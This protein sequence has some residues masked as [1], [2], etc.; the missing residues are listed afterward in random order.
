MANIELKVS[1]KVLA[2]E[3]TADSYV[4]PSGDNAL[5]YYFEGSAPDSPLTV[6]RLVWDFG[7]VGEEDLWV[8]QRQGIMPNREFST[9]VIGD[10]VKKLAVVCDNGCTSDY[11]FNAFAKVKV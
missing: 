2:G 7:G 9:K 6:V 3:Q 4:V 11:Y 5:I 10:G 1:Q 8:L